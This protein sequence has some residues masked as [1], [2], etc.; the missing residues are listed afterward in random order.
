MEACAIKLDDIIPIV[1]SRV[2]IRMYLII[3]SEVL[4]ALHNSQQHEALLDHDREGSM[5]IGYDI[6]RIK[7]C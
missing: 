2:L 4:V 7:G 3:K 6:Y 5:P 1:V